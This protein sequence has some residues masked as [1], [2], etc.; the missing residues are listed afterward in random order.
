MQST[1]Y[2]PR[3]PV[4]RADPRKAPSYQYSDGP[5]NRSA[6]QA[7]LSSLRQAVAAAAGDLKPGAWIVVGTNPAAPNLLRQAVAGWH[8]VRNGGNAYDAD[9]MAKTLTGYGLRDERQFPHGAWSARAGRG[10]THR[11]ADGVDGVGHVEARGPA[12]RGAY[13]MA[14]PDRS[15]RTGQVMR[16]H[17]R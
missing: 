16:Q 17:E 13:R 9:R 10:A 7:R 14:G 2:S 15:S 11:S 5:T 8:A 1:A 12:S 3:S 6:A 4:T